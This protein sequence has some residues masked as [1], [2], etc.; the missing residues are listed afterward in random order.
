MKLRVLAISGS[1]RRVSANTA[2]LQAAALVAPEGVKVVLTEAVGALPHFNPDLEGAEPAVVLAWRAE[3]RA[4]EAILISSPEYAHG[5]PGALK[6]ALDWVVG[7][8]ELSAKPVA[9]WNA[10]PRATLAQASLAEIIRTMDAKLCEAAGVTLP[11][12]GKG[13][14]AVS[15][16]AV[17]AWAAELREAL[18]RLR[19]SAESASTH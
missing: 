2:L 14:D 9:L 17:P 4:A 16:V 6:N 1:L 11:L 18:A 13:L 3:L 7:S 12:L 15:I 5:V 19:E 8:G 10:S